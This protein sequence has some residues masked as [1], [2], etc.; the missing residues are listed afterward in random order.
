MTYGLVASVQCPACGQFFL[1]Q[2]QAAEGMVTCPHCA[3]QGYRAHFP[4]QGQAA[5]L[6]AVRRAV[7]QKAAEESPPA[8]WPV[9]PPVQDAGI[10]PS[11]FNP[12]T[13]P[14]IWRQPTA[15][16]PTAAMQPALQLP[17]MDE[18]D[19]AARA[20]YVPPHLQR[21]PWKAVLLFA[22]MLAALGGGLWVW[23][24]ATNGRKR[25]A[26]A[27]MT[28]QEAFPAPDAG[29]VRR[30]T[31]PSAAET[32]EALQPQNDAL[33]MRDDVRRCVDQLFSGADPQA[34]LDAIHDG[35][36][37]AA[38]VAAFMA[39]AGG[40][41]PQLVKLAALKGLASLLPGGEKL[42]LFHLTTTTCPEGA[43]LRLMEDA[44]GRRLHWALLQD[45]HEHLLTKALTAAPEQPVWSWALI[46]P[47]HG[48][49]VSPTERGRYVTFALHVTA[50]GRHPVVACTERDTPLGRYLE[51]ETEWGQAY[52]ARLLLRRL[53]VETGAEAV[54]IVDCEGASVESS[55]LPK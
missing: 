8:A 3:H 46:K 17:L 15:T 14:Q 49:E 27:P 1:C 44:A 31:L 43:F 52:L 16:A 18:A 10:A 55:V 33:A 11:H 20:A 54:I 38:E 12:P 32:A 9:A 34:R 47:S 23:W 48:F 39:P 53:K 42:P 2:Q 24:D 7:Y 45:S 26:N 4:T 29:E 5:G 51:R 25:P 30:A 41:P 19:D 21:S 13:Q 36:R 6:N 40:K 50:D 37:H 35:E 28:L 22:V